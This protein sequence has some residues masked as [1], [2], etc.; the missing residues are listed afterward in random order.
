M[1]SKKLKGIFFLLGVCFFAYQFV[2]AG[3]NTVNLEPIVIHKD[4][5][6]LTQDYALKSRD[7][8]N[9]PL[10][11]PVEALSNL[12]VDLQ[13]RSLKDGIQTDFSLR[14]SNFQ[15]VLMLLD[16]QRINDPQTGHF[17][18]DLPLT[19][20]DIEKIEVMPGVGSSLFGPDAIGG[21]IN[22]VTKAPDKPKMVLEFS[23]GQHYAQGGIFSVTQKCDNV[24]LRVSVERDKS[25]GFR[26]DTDFKK[27]TATINSLVNFADNEFKINLGYQNK[28]FGAFDFYTPG[29]GFPSREWTKTWLLDTGL[30]LNTE[31]GLSIKPN[32][33]WRRHYDKFMLDETQ[34]KSKYLNYH[35]SD[36]YTPSIYFKKNINYLGQLGLGLE[37]GREQIKSTNL[38]KHQRDHGSVFMD[39][40]K[41][42]NSQVS[43]AL[44]GRLDNFDSFGANGSGSATLK[45][46]LTPQDALHLGVSRSIRIPTFTELYYSDP[47]TVG[48]P[49]LAAE[50]SL[51][52]ETGYEYKRENLSFGLIAFL[53]Q[54]SDAIDWVRH[55][56]IE[57]WAA[58]NINQAQFKGLETNFKISFNHFFSASSNYTYTDRHADDNGLLYKYGPTYSRHLVSAALIFNWL[59]FVQSFSFN[60]KKQPSRGGWFTINTRFSYNFYPNAQLFMEA[61]NL[62]AKEFSDIPGIPQPKRWI[63]GGLRFDW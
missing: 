28:E 1:F 62:L 23:G 3:D 25:D 10:N 54:E 58:Q 49:N 56:P 14:G 20:E 15:G 19:K 43:L 9:L 22:F 36:M 6:V 13:S 37:Y 41:E 27:L 31:G 26:Y 39:D 63:E 34:I 55:T 35:H 11:S 59:K 33:L 7:I 29:S 2:F 21:A 40:L 52:Y 4:K 24:G 5:A 44:S 16:G 18:S 12:P 48:N 38:G 32:F 46:N 60:Y 42:I 53:R 30:N 17:N 50:K 57:K 8:D 61:D 47:T 45:F 51:N